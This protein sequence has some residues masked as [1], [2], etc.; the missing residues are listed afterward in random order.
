MNSTLKYIFHFTFIILVQVLIL[1][2][3]NIP[4]GSFTLSIFVFPLVIILLPFELENYLALLFAFAL[5]LIT[6]MFYNSPGVFASASV[7][8]AF[9]RPLILS[10]NEPKTGYGRDNAPLISS[11]GLVWFL[12]YSVPIVLAFILFYCLVEV[13]AFSRFG[14]ALLEVV[15]SLPI[16]M[17]FVVL[18]VLILNPKL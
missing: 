14:V 3:I 1:Q 4:I 18:Y 9:I 2:N 10:L 6:D 16:S 15:I 13:F 5:G 8:A 17:V 12:K 11:M 7:F